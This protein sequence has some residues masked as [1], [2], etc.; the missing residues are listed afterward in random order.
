LISKIQSAISAQQ[1][2]NS[3]KA[4]QRYKWW[5]VQSWAPYLVGENPDGSINPHT[6]ELFV[7]QVSGSI[8]PAPQVQE[9]LKQ[10]SNTVDNSKSIEISWP[11]TMKSD[12]DLLL[13]LEQASF[14][15]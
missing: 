15:L 6:T 14:R 12:I 1:R 2:L 9:A 10:I 3:I 5:P 11:V 8:I 4:S 13:L 7:P